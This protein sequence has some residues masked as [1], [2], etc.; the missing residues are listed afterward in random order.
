MV[1]K[2][3]FDHENSK[4]SNISLKDNLKRII[5]YWQNTLMAN[6]SVSHIIENGYKI[7]FFRRQKKLTFLTTNLRLKTKS[8]Y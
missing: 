1:N 7:L 3:I 4:K 2:E 8:L 5:V 6:K